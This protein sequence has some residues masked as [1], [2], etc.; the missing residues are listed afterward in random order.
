M[1]PHVPEVRNSNH[2]FRHIDKIV[3]RH[4][5]RRMSASHRTEILQRGA[6]LLT[7]AVVTGM[8]MYVALMNPG[9]FGDAIPL[10][11]VLALVN[12]AASWFAMNDCS[13]QQRL[14]VASWTQLA[15]SLAIGWVMPV[16]FTPIYSIIWMAI[17]PS[18][19]SNRTCWWLLGGT[20]IAW[21]VIMRFGWGDS[22]A[23]LSAILYS[24]FLLFALLTSR[25]AREAENA[26]DQVQLLNRELLA[27]QHLLDEAS[28]QSERTRIARDLHDLLGHHLTALSINLQIAEHLADGEAKDKVAESRALARLLL[29]DVR[30]AVD[31][32]R[33]ERSVDLR[34]AVA[35]LTEN[36][37]SLAVHV[38]I[39]DDV[40]IDNVDIAQTLVR[41]VQEA[42]TN[43][44]RHAEAAN[45][46]IRLWQEGDRLNLEVRDDGRAADDLDEGNGLTGMRE[47]LA[48][49]SGSLTLDRVGDALRL[50]ASIPVSQP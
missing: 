5:N 19:F 14:Y 24:T 15:T 20:A 44:L 13:S 36:T 8:V 1:S 38:D 39:A 47:R 12:V 34:S 33:E 22:S 27:T 42:I 37:P 31:T 4:H 46:W 7:W 35:V 26:R 43:T 2:D 30:D 28:R 16:S 18:I 50:Q 40:E 21:F 41:C 10:T 3:A 23:L 29:S 11:A 6:G 17:A 49:L 32:L 25:N 45:C 48:H 9:R